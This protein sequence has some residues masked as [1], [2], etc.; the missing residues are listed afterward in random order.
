MALQ[1]ADCIITSGNVGLDSIEPASCCDC[2]HLGGVLVHEDFFG[3]E[4]V[5]EWF[6]LFFDFVP[7]EVHAKSYHS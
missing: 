7:R 3:M 6:S 5:E 2:T 1:L 4:P